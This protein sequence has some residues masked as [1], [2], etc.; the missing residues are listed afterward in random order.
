MAK[1]AKQANAP[2]GKT[3]QPTFADLVHAVQIVGI[4]MNDLWAQRHVDDDAMPETLS[5]RG[6]EKA[7]G[8]VRL[9]REEL[10]V[11]VQFTFRATDEQDKDVKVADAGARFVVRYRVP[12]E[13]L[14]SLPQEVVDEFATRNGIFNAWPY[15]REYLQTTMMRLG[16]PGIIAPVYRIPAA[17]GRASAKKKAKARTAK[18]AQAKK[19]GRS[20]TGTTRKKRT[21]AKQA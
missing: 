2:S 13:L 11:L 16:I 21:P 19:D 17:R 5:L 4:R 14:E 20:T 7:A 1:K 3:A 18:T 15:W 6:A 9:N 8:E 12:R 10:V